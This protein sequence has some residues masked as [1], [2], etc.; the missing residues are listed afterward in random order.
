MKLAI[1]RTIVVE[2]LYGLRFHYFSFCPSCH[3]NH[4][5][6]S[7]LLAISED[8]VDGDA[9]VPIIKLELSGIS[10]N[11]I[12][13]RLA[14]QSVPITLTLKNTS[15]LCDL[16]DRNLRS[17]NETRVTDEILE[18]FPQQKTFRTTLRGIK[19]WAQRRAIYSNVI[20]FPGGVA[21]AM[22][23]VK[24]CQLYHQ[25]TGSVHNEKFFLMIGK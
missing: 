6:P 5:F 24:M 13:A 17:L 25:A 22:L 14:L 16:E 23:I 4:P 2:S 8:L 21:W 15:I 1:L 20:G 9:Y 10:I 12:F 7:S 18:L 19:L 11:L 3:T